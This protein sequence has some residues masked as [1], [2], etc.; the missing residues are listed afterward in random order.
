[1][2]QNFFL[3]CLPSKIKKNQH[4]A[5]NQFKVIAVPVYAVSA[6]ISYPDWY[7]KPIIPQNMNKKKI[8]LD[9]AIS[10]NDN[11]SCSQKAIK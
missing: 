10:C 9:V 7:L 1:M 6:Q 11:T 8:Q 5:Q 3:F 2:N 4:M